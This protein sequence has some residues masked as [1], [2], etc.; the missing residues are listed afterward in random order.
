MDTRLKGARWPVA[1]VPGE[2]DGGQG[3]RLSVY[4]WCAWGWLMALALLVLA[5]TAAAEDRPVRFAVAKLATP[6][7]NIP[8][9]VGLFGGNDGKTLT[10]D[11][12]FQIRSLEFIAL[13]GT[14]F[15]IEGVIHRF[16]SIVYRVTTADY[17]FATKT[18]YYL[19]SRFVTLTPSRRAER[20]RSLPPRQEVI[21]R[22]LAAQGTPYLWGG[23]L[24]GGIPQML[25]LYPPA[26]AVVLAS[27]MRNVWQLR[28]LDCSG[29][30]YEA[31]GGCTPRNTSALITYGKP[32]RIAGLGVEQIIERVEPLDLIAWEGH[33]VIVLDRERAIESR[34]DCSGSGR[35]VEVRPLREVLAAVL[36]SRVPVD[37]YRSLKA[38]GRKGFV[39]RRWYGQVPRS[40]DS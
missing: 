7:F 34:L 19:D 20:F 17:P 22:L 32:V 9:F 25:A 29:L 14:V 27:V 11:R 39:I 33:V 40:P 16:P 30:L 23:N 15:T 38:K 28:G 4:R 24:R 13:P 6:V 37:D 1:R 35:G 31:T 26:E 12:C 21:E 8:D 18:G 5:G 36:A 3:E 2:G 10:V